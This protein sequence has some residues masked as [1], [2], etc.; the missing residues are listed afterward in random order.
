VRYLTTNFERMSLDNHY[1]QQPTQEEVDAC[2]DAL[3]HEVSQ[4][5]VPRPSRQA[6]ALRE[7]PRSDP[8]GL[9][10]FLLLVGI[11]FLAWLVSMMRF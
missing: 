10:W 6:P 4:H 11:G 3:E 5:Q 8:G 2:L 1:Q 9:L 7:A